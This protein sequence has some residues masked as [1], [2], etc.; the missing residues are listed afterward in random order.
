MTINKTMH[1]SANKWNN[2]VPSDLQTPLPLLELFPIDLYPKATTNKTPLGVMEIA[3]LQTP[4][5]T[6]E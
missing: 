3:P 5:S 1:Q 6:W 4:L 2:I